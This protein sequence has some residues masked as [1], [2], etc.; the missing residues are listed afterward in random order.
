[1]LDFSIIF[2]FLKIFKG[3]KYNEIILSCYLVFFNFNIFRWVL[4]SKMIFGDMVSC[5]LCDVLYISGLL[6]LLFNLCILSLY[7][8][9]LSFLDLN[10]GIENYEEV[11]KF[12][13]CCDN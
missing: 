5:L 3:Y 4:W 7:W 10:V 1:M 12:L 2:V 9:F 6:I 8:Y 13:S 11:I